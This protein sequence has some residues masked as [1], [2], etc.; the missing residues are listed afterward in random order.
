MLSCFFKESIPHPK[1]LE[2][3]PLLEMGLEIAELDIPF[4]GLIKANGKVFNS[5]SATNACIETFIYREKR[6]QIQIKTIDYCKTLIALKT[7]A[8]ASLASKFLEKSSWREF[9]WTKK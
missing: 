3:L 2:A 9:N 7:I 6:L 8:F 4:Q 5:V 1:D